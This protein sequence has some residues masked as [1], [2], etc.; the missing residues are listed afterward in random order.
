MYYYHQH[1]FNKDIRNGN[2]AKAGRE[3]R[4]IGEGRLSVQP[5]MAIVSIGVETEDMEL[6][7]ALS[8][9][10]EIIAKIQQGLAGIGISEENIQTNHFTIFPIYDIVDGMQT[11]R[12]YRVE[13][14]L[15]VTVLDVDGVG[16]LVDTAVKNGA[17]RVTNISFQPSNP[18]KAYREALQLAVLDAIEKAKSISNTLQIPL[19]ETPRKVIEEKSRFEGPIPYAQS[20]MVKAASTEIEPGRQEIT[21]VVTAIFYTST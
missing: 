15:G 4:V 2:K 21:A 5:D 8:R 12:G 18:S 17:N 3:I 11:F 6:E 14:M 7:R 19:V 13:H 9:N 20:T 1:A 10:A 16:T